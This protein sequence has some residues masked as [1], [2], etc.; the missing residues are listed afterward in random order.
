MK[1]RMLGTVCVALVTAAAM[2]AASSNK[3]DKGKGRSP[4]T[5]TATAAPRVAVPRTASKTQPTSQPKTQVQAVFSSDHVRVMRAHYGPRYR[6]LP[7]GLQKKYA[8][9]GQLPPGWQKKMEPLPVAIERSLPPLPVEYR[10]GVIDGHAVIYHSSAG[11]IID[12][13]VLF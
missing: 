1:G 9:T 6:Q 7:P 3:N 11:T 10:R 2:P 4:S 13:A 12:V 5:A 8:R